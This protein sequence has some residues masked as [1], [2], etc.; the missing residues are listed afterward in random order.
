M[1]PTSAAYKA[2]IDEPNRLVQL[3]GTI[4]LK[5]SSVLQIGDEDILQGSL[6]LREQCVA[7][8]DFEIGN[9][10]AAE[11]GFGLILTERFDNRI[12]EEGI[13]QFEFGIEISPGEFEFVPLGVFYIIEPKRKESIID[14]KAFD[15]LIALDED[16]R[17]IRSTGTPFQFL[18]SIANK[19]GV[20]LAFTES[21][22]LSLPNG[23]KRLTTPIDSDIETCRDIVS[24]LAQLTACFARMDRFGKLE[25]VSLVG[26]EVNEID[27]DPRFSTSVADYRYQ[28]YKMSM[29]SGK[30]LYENT[31]S[32]DDGNYL[33]LPENPFLSSESVFSRKSIIADIFNAVSQVAYTPFETEYFG[34]PAIQPGDYIKLLG[35]VAQSGVVG[36]VTHSTWRYRGKHKIRSVGTNPKLRVK[37]SDMRDGAAGKGTNIILVKNQNPVN[38]AT[39]YQM[40]LSINIATFASTNAQVGLAIVGQAST[41]GIL[42]EGYFEIDGERISTELKQV[43]NQGWN[44]I[45]LPFIIPQIQDGSHEIRFFLKTSTGTFNI[46]NNR[47][48][49]FVVAEN[50]LG[51][52]SSSLPRADIVDEVTFS[53]MNVSENRIVIQQVPIKRNITEQ[54]TIA[55]FNVSENINIE[56]E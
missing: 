2:A 44:T 50:L 9:A 25:F 4:T 33:E 13:V 43:L 36:L 19:I 7:S 14:I 35:G 49:L 6:Y 30:T 21:E 22:M 27:S 11:M 56:M 15:G 23:D 8:D 20:E 10:I 24:W 42:L 31:A 16:L 55:T 32:V 52:M 53:T 17:G 26:V 1:Y 40:L 54:V 12:F 47:A 29:V 3:R 34:D 45:G 39:N 38:I 41:S 18:Q 51:G 5:D 46:E 37:N 48:E 28:V